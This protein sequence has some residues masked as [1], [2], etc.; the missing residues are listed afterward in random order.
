MLI[1]HQDIR[2]QVSTPLSAIYIL[3]GQENFLIDQA[4]STLKQTWNS[5]HSQG[6]DVKVMDIESSGDWARLMDTVNNY[7]L[8]AEAT[9]VDA[10]YAKKSLDSDGKAFFESYLTHI[11]ADCLLLLRAPDLTQKTLQFLV[12]HPQVTLVQTKAPDKASVQ[13][14]VKE[15]LAQHAIR[16]QGAVLPLIEQYTRGNLAACAQLL[17]KIKITHDLEHELTSTLLKQ[18]LF[19][20]AQYQLFELSDACLLG[21][22]AQALLIL[23][24]AAENRVEWTLILWV[25]AQEVRLLL[26]L[27]HSNHQNLP[28]STT[29]SQLKIW[30]QRGKLYQAALKRHTEESLYRLL[31]FCG[32]LDTLIKTSQTPQTPRHFELLV[33]GLC[34]GKQVLLS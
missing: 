20:Q 2:F 21:D 24:H 8:F 4:V 9:L 28:F 34:S 25:L 12:N 30:P 16:Y 23:R 17:D 19:D 3:M 29:L 5:L 26:Q 31:A 33:V 18:Y 10:R 7:S 32:K 15:Q 6:S 22:T 13:R 27:H 11:N 1:K 14:W